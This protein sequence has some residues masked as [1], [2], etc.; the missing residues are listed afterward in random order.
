MLCFTS[1][2]GIFKKIYKIVMFYLNNIEKLKVVFLFFF[3]SS[4]FVC[5]QYLL[6]ISLN[7]LFSMCIESFLHVNKELLNIENN[8]LLIMKFFLMNFFFCLI[9][10]FAD[11]SNDQYRSEL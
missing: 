1:G 9:M 3:Y 5:N 6:S 10:K 11:E 2:I 4:G 8:F 7:N